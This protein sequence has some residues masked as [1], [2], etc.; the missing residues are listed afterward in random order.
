L[1]E[2]LQ[3]GFR[4]SRSFLEKSEP[5]SEP[6]RT[7][8][9]IAADLAD[10]SATAGAAARRADRQKKSTTIRAMRKPKPGGWEA[11]RAKAFWLTGLSGY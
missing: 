1:T 9:I 3:G 6:I 11:I 8:T 10:N 7:G 5:K 2:C 4:V